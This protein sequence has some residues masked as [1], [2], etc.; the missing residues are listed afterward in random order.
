MTARDEIVTAIEGAAD[1]LKDLEPEAAQEAGGDVAFM[2]A[3]LP[4]LAHD[5]AIWSS[6]RSS[7]SITTTCRT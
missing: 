5:Q 3:A 1:I 7:R 4:H 6:Q 2:V